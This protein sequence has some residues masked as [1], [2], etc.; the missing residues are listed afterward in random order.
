MTNFTESR[1]SRS[2]QSSID[3]IDFL[4]DFWIKICFVLTDSA[5]LTEAEV[6]RG[7]AKSLSE[8]VVTIQKIIGIIIV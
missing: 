5:E 7:E 6:E 4:A 8:T 3:D 1:T 2:A